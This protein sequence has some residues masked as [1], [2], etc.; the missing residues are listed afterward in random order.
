MLHLITVKYDLEK[1]IIPLYEKAGMKAVHLT[2][3]EVRAF[4]RALKPVVG[5]WVKQV[6]ADTGN[7]ALEL[8]GVK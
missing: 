2:K 7:K 1:D 3:D 8:A 4:E 5:W 6:G